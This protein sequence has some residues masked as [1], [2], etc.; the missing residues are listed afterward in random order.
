MITTIFKAVLLK[1][2]KH[3]FEYSVVTLIFICVMFTLYAKAG[4]KGYN[5]K[6]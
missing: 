6:D 4:S 2:Y 3:H 5:L 1:S